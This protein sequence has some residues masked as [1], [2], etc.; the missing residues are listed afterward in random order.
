MKA[1]LILSEMRNGTTWACS[2]TNSTG[3]LGRAGEPLRREIS[4]NQGS[5]TAD[6]HY[7]TIVKKSATDNGVFSL[8]V[9]PEHLR[10]VH[11]E[12]GYDFIARCRDEHELHIVLLERRDLLG[13]AISAVRAAQSGEWHDRKG[14][15]ATDAQGGVPFHYDGDRIFER[16][17]FIGDSFG[18]W[19]KYL[20]FRGLDYVHVYYEDILENWAGYVDLIARQVGVEIDPACVVTDSLKVQRDDISR[21]WRQR[22]LEDMQSRDADLVNLKGYLYPRNLSNALSF[23]RKL[24]LRA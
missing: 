4:K 8:K 22:F 24:P 19:R 9:F 23:I 3:K 17:R 6:E 21:Q 14:M 5:A 2:M 12:Y 10:F 16:T 11:D 18:F 13:A 1:L 20:A 15:P 7:G